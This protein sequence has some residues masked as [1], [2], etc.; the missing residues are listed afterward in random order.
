MTP[1]RILAVVM[2]GNMQDP[3]KWEGALGIGIAGSIYIDMV[4]DLTDPDYFSERR[5]WRNR[6]NIC[7]AFLVVTR[8]RRRRCI[9]F[10][11]PHFESSLF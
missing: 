6:R 8:R 4:G 3:Q 10:L 1:S 7:S 5:G 11:R 9:L 2:D